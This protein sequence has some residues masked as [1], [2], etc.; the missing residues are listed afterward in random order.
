MQPK[1]IDTLI[2]GFVPPEIVVKKKVIIVNDQIPSAIVLHT[3]Q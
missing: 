3:P 2:F 1:L